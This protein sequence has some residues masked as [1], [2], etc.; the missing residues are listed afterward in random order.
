MATRFGLSWRDAW[1]MDA[2]ERMAY[3]LVAAES[4]GNE[5]R[6]MTDPTGRLIDVRVRQPEARRDSAR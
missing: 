5:V 2:R 4:E 1:A 3:L 6:W